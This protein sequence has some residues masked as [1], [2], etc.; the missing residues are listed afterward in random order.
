[1]S[2]PQRPSETVFYALGS[3]LIA[4]YLLVIGKSVIVPVLI[5]LIAVFVLARVVEWLGGFRAFSHFPI[6]VLHLFVLLIA[7]MFFMAIGSIVAAN[8]EDMVDKAPAYQANLL[9]LMQEATRLVGIENDPSWQDVRGVTLDRIDLSA[10]AGRFF[11][12]LASFS[13]ALFLVIV[14]TAFL[15]TEFANL[16]TKIRLA[17]DQNEDGTR[18]LNVLGE[19][20]QKVSDYLSAKTGINILLGVISYVILWGFDIDFAAFW[21]I[22]IMLLNYVPYV[23]SAAAVLLPMVT[24]MAQFGSLW[25]TLLLTAALVAA[26]MFVGNFVEPRWIGRQLNLAPFSI[27]L[28]LS[29]WSSMWGIVGALLAV[30]LTSVLVIVFRELPGTRPIAVLISG[31]PGDDTPTQDVQENS[32]NFR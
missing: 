24:S 22:C 20:N 11:T 18:I 10:T 14:Y 17:Y 19:I 4:G 2:Q 32:Q 27:I 6:W 21:A 23:G 9:S 8:L 3:A 7:V 12:S 1:M 26:Q 15:M 29:V 28:S 5:A 30:P 13:G 16:P 31:M 25:T